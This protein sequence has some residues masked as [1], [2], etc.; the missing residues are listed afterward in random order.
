MI[1]A[2]PNLAAVYR[3]KGDSLEIH[4]ARREFVYDRAIDLAPGEYLICRDAVVAFDDEGEPLVVRDGK[5]APASDGP[6]YVGIGEPQAPRVVQIVPADDWVIWRVDNDGPW[7][8]RLAAWGLTASGNVVPL[9]TDDSGLVLEFDEKDNRATLR[10]VSEGE[11]KEWIAERQA[12]IKASA[13]SESKGPP[14]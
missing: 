3:I 4:P 1:T 13:P 14:S 7:S 10:H 8:T 5:L 12:E 2:P 9:Q 6:N 11:P